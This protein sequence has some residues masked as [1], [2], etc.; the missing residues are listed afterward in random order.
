[1]ERRVGDAKGRLG[2]HPG[3]LGIADGRNHVARV[4]KSAE[5][6]GDVRALGLLDFV[7][8]LTQ[9][10]CARAHPKPV[11]GPVKHMCL[12]SGLMERLGP[13][14][15]GAVR[16]FSVEQVDLLEAAA[17]GL[18]AVEASH[19]DDNRC[20]AHQL[21]NARLVFAGALPHVP[22]DKAEFDFPSHYQLILV[23]LTI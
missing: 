20:D 23:I 10:L 21:V 1:M 4:V 3:L 9:V 5:D 8:Q 17:V 7:E 6:A 12:D 15:Y 14:P 16:V 22:E 2:N 11:Q 19:F 18:D 13:F